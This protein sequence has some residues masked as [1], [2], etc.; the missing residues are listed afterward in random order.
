MNAGK[1]KKVKSPRTPSYALETSFDDAKRLYD[2]F[3]HASFSKAEIASSLSLSATSSSL[4]K[5]VFALTEYGLLD[6]HGDQFSVSQVFHTLDSGPVD[7]ANFKTA[8]LQA[9]K[10][11]D[12]FAEILEDFRTK[13]PDMDVISQRLE[14]QKGFNA[15]RAKEVASILEKSMR[16]A[17]VLDAN[18]NILPVRDDQNNERAE[19]EQP[20]GGQGSENPQGQDTDNFRVPADGLR[21][22]EVPLGEG[23]VAIVLYPEDLTVA[24]AG[25][26]GNV[27]QALVS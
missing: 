20:A 25:K 19:G 6:N 26:V 8:A 9:I 11:S 1:S 18:N 21:R 4:T 7:G 12:V 10:R 13:L 14:K 23:R 16:F 27:L 5:R 22:T 3:S 2:N 17:G 15:D 24:E